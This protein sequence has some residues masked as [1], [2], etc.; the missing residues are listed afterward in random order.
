LIAT[1]KGFSDSG[2]DKTMG[3]RKAVNEREGGDCEIEKRT[4]SCLTELFCSTTILKIKHGINLFL[5]NS[6]FLSKSSGC[7]VY[8]LS[9]S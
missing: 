9:A 5:F 4:L 1:I 3:T 2:D 8:F 6:S 7:Q